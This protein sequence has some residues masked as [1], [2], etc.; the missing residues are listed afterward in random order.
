MKKIVY[1][2]CLLILGLDMQAQIDPYDNNWDTLLLDNFSNASWNTWDN[3]LISHGITISNNFEI[4]TGSQ[5]SLI[6][7]ECPE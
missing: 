2:C 4:Q 5:V 3:W 1:L 7:E 6:V